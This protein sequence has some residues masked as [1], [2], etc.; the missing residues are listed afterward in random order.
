MAKNQKKD[1]I[2]K[3]SFEEAIKSLTDI[4]AG[5]EQ[6]EIPLQRSLDE[7]EKAMSLVKHCREILKQAEKRIKN[8]AVDQPESEDDQQDSEDEL[9]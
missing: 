6:G 4:V 3:L 1:D 7:Y 2:G 9:F 8:A 5:I